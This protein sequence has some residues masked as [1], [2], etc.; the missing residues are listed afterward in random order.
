MKANYTLSAARR[1]AERYENEFNVKVNLGQFVVGE[2][3]DNYLDGLL[4]ELDPV[5]ACDKEPAG[6]E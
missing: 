3:L 2:S 1:I 4:E 5:L 6:D